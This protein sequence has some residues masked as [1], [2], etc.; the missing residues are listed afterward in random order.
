MA[1]DFAVELGDE[2]HDVRPAGPEFVE[3]RTRR[4]PAECTLVDELDEREVVCLLF[5]D[6]DHAECFRGAVVAIFVAMT[7]LGGSMPAGD[8]ARPSPAAAR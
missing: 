5:A 2:R 8:A 1:D 3:L 4:R 7:G 6:R